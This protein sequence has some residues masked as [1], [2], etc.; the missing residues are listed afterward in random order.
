MRELA[1]AEVV[2]DAGADRSAE[3]ARELHR[4]PPGARGELTRAD[5]RHPRTA[6]GDVAFRFLEPEGLAQECLLTYGE[7]SGRFFPTRSH[8]GTITS[9][10]P[11]SSRRTSTVSDSCR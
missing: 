11:A 9:A 2:L 1:Q 10:R 5:R 6:V 7:T 4:R 3:L 8:Y